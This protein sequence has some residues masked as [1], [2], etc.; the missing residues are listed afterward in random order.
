M[1]TLYTLR[2]KDRQGEYLKPEYDG[3]SP[4]H[5][6]HYTHYFK[7]KVREYAESNNL[8]SWWIDKVTV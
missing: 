5:W 4:E 6:N 3:K 8:C 1:K 7:N 2:T